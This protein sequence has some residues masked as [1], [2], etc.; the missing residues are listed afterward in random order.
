VNRKTN[1]C[2]GQGE[3]DRGRGETPSR[4]QAARRPKREEQG[5]RPRGGR[6]TIKLEDP[7]V[8][9]SAGTAAMTGSRKGVQESQYRE[10]KIPKGRSNGKGR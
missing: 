9:G 4:G 2:E 3:P 5:G 6:N 10:E 7:H 1:V 8:G